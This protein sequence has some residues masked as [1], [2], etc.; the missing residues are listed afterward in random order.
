[1]LQRISGSI[2]KIQKILG[3]RSEI[4]VLVQRVSHHIINKLL[5]RSPLV[6]R[7]I[8]SIEAKA[9]PT[10]GP[11]FFKGVIFYEGFNESLVSKEKLQNSSVL[12]ILDD[13]MT[14]IKF[15]VLLNIFLVMSHHRRVNPVYI[16]TFFFIRTLIFKLRLNVIKFLPHL[17]LKTF[18]KCS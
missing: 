2:Q 17:R 8:L 11:N 9:Y 3:R 18:L 16:Y 1:M 4:P 15:D 10:V 14:S 7:P 6:T 12:L 13:L 5:V